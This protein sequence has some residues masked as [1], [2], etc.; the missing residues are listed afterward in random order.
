[1]TDQKNLIK[2]LDDLNKNY[3]EYRTIREE[4]SKKI[5]DILNKLENILLNK[6][7]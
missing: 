1:M 6:E 2:I 5:H 7:I 3:E 4:F